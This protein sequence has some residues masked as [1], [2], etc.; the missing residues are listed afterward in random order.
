MKA[1]GSMRRPVSNATALDADR[2]D[3]ANI[4]LVSVAAGPHSLYLNSLNLTVFAAYC[5][6]SA[7]VAVPVVLI[8]TIASEIA[9]EGTSSG[10][11]SASVA[12]YATLGTSLGKAFNGFVCDSLGARRTMCLAFLGNTFGLF[13]YSRGSNALTVGLASALIEYNNSVHWPCMT[14]IVSSHYASDPGRLEAAIFM[15]SLAS[16]FGAVVSMPLWNLLKS[17]YGWRDVALCSSLVPAAGFLIVALLI[18]DMPGRRNVPQGKSLSARSI[19]ASLRAVLGSRLF[20]LVGGA[21]VGNGLIRTSER[22]VGSYYSETAGVDNDTAGGLTTVVS[23]GFLFG[24]L[25]FGNVFIRVKDSNKNVF[26]STLYLLCILS[27]LSL[28]FLSMPFV[29]IGDATIYLETGF[30]F[31]AASMIA[32]QYYQVPTRLASTFGDNKGLC[33]S[34]IDG[35]AYASTA[36]IW[37][38]LSFIVELGEYGWAYLWAAVALFVTA[39]WMLQSKFSK[40]FWQ[41]GDCAGVYEKVKEEEVESVRDVG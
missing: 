26:T 6:S 30:T 15:L 9:P 3:D 21:Q 7:S 10:S 31:T 25:V 33:S 18:E 20:W 32:V 37:Q 34:Y 28:G 12:A 5:L 1:P 27:V 22:V 40:I 29:S 39:A 2:K 13:L 14:I 4:S 19:L 11:F 24:V 38:G 16:R 41:D 8:N 36:V 23:L 17:V 35:I